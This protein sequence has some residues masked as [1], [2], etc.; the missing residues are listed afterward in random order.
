[1]TQTKLNP[2]E[3]MPEAIIRGVAAALYATQMDLSNYIINGRMDLGS[4]DSMIRTG[5]GAFIL[6]VESFE[7]EVNP[8][9]P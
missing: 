1:M 5:V 9:K 6:A 7:S 8:N 3:L 2:D 4:I